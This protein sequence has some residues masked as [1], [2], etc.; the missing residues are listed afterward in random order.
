MKYTD[1]GNLRFSGNT[2]TSTSTQGVERQELDSGKWAV[3]LTNTEPGLGYLGYN[4]E[5]LSYD[6]ENSKLCTEN[7]STSCVNASDTIYA[8]HLESCCGLCFECGCISNGPGEIR[9]YGRPND[10]SNDGCLVIADNCLCYC[11]SNGNASIVVDNDGVRF[12]GPISADGSCLYVE[13]YLI[14]NCLYVDFN[15]QCHYIYGIRKNGSNIFTNSG[16]LDIGTVG[17]SVT[18]NGA[19]TFANASGNINLGTISSEVVLNSAC[20]FVVTDGS[21]SNILNSV[22][23][24][25]G[26]GLGTGVSNAI[27]MGEN[28]SVSGAYGVTIGTE[29]FAGCYSNSIGCAAVANNYSTA[30]GF[31]STA[32]NYAIALGHNAYARNGNIAIG[33]NADASSECLNYIVTKAES[34]ICTGKTAGFGSTQIIVNC[35]T[36]QCDLYTVLKNLM[37]NAYGTGLVN[38]KGYLL[39]N[40]AIY[41]CTCDYSIIGSGDYN[42]PIFYGSGSI[43]VGEY[44][45]ESYRMSICSTCTC[46]VTIKYGSSYEVW[47]ILF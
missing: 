2:R 34:C 47:D 6:F 30:I 23:I 14:A 31:N 39:L 42:L 41:R 1:E 33:T 20:S 45:S 17:S 44:G 46:K 21:F 9:I 12:Y 16:V 38:N 37:T 3:T 7:I 5:A 15:C 19:T 40:K 13:D 22:I 29:S 27:V 26:I 25:C 36:L 11:T 18:V 32:Y 24:G 43:D 10:S 8:Q 35:S 28:A 4:V